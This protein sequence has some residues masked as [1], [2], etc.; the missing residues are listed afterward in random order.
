[1]PSVDPQPE[2]QQPD[3]SSSEL[4][5]V[6]EFGWRTHSA[7][8]AWTAKVDTKASIV[9]ALDGVV[10]AA[11][12]GGHN[13][14]GVLDQLYGWRNV[15]QGAAAVLVVLALIVAGLVVRPALGSSREHKRDFRDNLIY[16]GHLRHWHGQTGEL[17]DRLRAGSSGDQ[18]EQLAAQLINMAR[19][20]WWKHQ[21][22][23]VALYVS[24]AAAVCLT[25]AVLW[26]Y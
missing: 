12:I 18:I 5:T 22:L 15:L 3:S 7:Q 17:A 26:P 14:G 6:I 11:I 16:F 21:L 13:E 24:G 23:Q 25:L 19:R 2:P 1:M 20:N 8:E 10:L 4:A 9:L